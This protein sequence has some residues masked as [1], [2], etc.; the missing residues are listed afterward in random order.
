LALVAWHGRA[1]SLVGSL[2]AEERLE[3]SSRFDPSGDGQVKTLAPKYAAGAAAR[4]SSEDQAVELHEWPAPGN[5][6]LGAREPSLEGV[7]NRRGERPKG[8]LNTEPDERISVWNKAS[9]SSEAERGSGPRVA[10]VTS[11]NGKG[12]D[13]TDEVVAL[14]GGRSP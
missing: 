13:A 14:R 2:R 9:K 6:S 4:P 12:A 11:G 7:E 1:G 8:R 3:T 5:R 10:S